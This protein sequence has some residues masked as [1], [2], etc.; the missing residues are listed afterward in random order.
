MHMT[1]SLSD[2]TRPTAV[3]VQWLRPQATAPPPLQAAAN[4]RA[5]DLMDVTVQFLSS[6][7][8]ALVL[9]G[10]IFVVLLTSETLY[11]RFA[12]FQ[13]KAGAERT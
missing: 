9:Q 6:S 5:F 12:I 4:A 10:I 3:G 13:Q 8:T 1:D 7:A 11:G 2:A